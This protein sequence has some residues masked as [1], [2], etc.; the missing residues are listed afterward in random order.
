MAASGASTF[1][2]RQEDAAADLL[3]LVTLQLGRIEVHLAND[4]AVQR[5][6]AQFVHPTRLHFLDFAADLKMPTFRKHDYYPFD[7]SLFDRFHVKLALAN[8]G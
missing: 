8:L 1:Y 7:N 4:A 3:L 6:M 5:R 2:I